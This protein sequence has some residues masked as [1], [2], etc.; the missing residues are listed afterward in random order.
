M[1]AAEQGLD[2]DRAL[3]RQ[4]D[5]R[6]VDVR[7]EG[8]AVLGRSCAAATSDITWKPPESVRIGR[9]QFMN[10]CS[11]P[12]AAMRSAPGRSIR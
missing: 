7:A 6:A 5:H 2:L 11:P 10:A 1:S 8:D 3:G 9:G 12:S 4:L